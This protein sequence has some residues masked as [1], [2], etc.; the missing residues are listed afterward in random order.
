MYQVVAHVSRAR[1]LI[2][3]INRVCVGMYQVSRGCVTVDSPS[4]TGRGQGPS[5]SPR[6]LWLYLLHPCTQT[7]LVPCTQTSPVPCT[8]TSPVPCTQTSPVPCTHWT[9]SSRWTRIG[10]S[11]IV[12]RDR[13]GEGGLREARGDIDRTTTP[14]TAVIKAHGSVTEQIR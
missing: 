12:G 14:V 11:L 1:V 4:R 7:S 2:G 10:V 5:D 8:Q 9:W 6:G 13:K 3:S